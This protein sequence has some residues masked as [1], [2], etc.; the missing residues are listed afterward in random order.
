MAKNVLDPSITVMNECEP[1]TI[2]VKEFLIDNLAAG[3][4]VGID[5]SLH[6]IESVQKLIKR[7]KVMGIHVAP[8]RQN[9][10]NKIWKDRP[11]HQL[12]G[13]IVLSQ[14]EHGRDARD[15]IKELR[16]KIAKKKC[17]SILLSALDEIM[18]KNES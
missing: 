6:C 9:L 17:N 3:D 1:D 12:K 16:E 15:K 10:V 14:E 18:C 8:I 7:L 5:P 11:A 13:P 4:W 2:S